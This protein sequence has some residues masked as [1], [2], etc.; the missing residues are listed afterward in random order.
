MPGDPAVNLGCL[1]APLKAP[2]SSGSR[3]SEGGG[4]SKRGVQPTRYFQTKRNGSI[5]I[6]LR[7]GAPSEAPLPEMQWRSFFYSLHAEASTTSFKPA[8][9]GERAMYLQLLAGLAG[10]WGDDPD[11]FIPSLDFVGDPGGALWKV[12]PVFPEAAVDITHLRFI[13]V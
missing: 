12:R 4:K 10:V 2:R 11:R 1:K 6:C 8:T 3:A 9:N 5:A 13:A 7:T